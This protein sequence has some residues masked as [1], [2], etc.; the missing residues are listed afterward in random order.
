[1]LEQML[2]SV[3]MN[4]GPQP[5]EVGYVSTLPSY[6][7]IGDYG[8]AATLLVDDLGEN[9]YVLG[10]YNSAGGLSKDFTVYNFFLKKWIA[11]PKIDLAETRHLSMGYVQDKIYVIN[12]KYIR[13]FD[14]AT[15]TWSSK[16]GVSSS[17]WGYFEQ[18]QACVVGTKIYFMGHSTDYAKGTGIVSYDTVTNTFALVNR[19]GTALKSYVSVKHI[20]GKLYCS[21]V[22]INSIDVYDITANTWTVY[23]ISEN[24]G[25]ANSLAY[26][27]DMYYFGTSTP[28]A[29]PNK[30]V[31]KFDTIT[32]T[33]TYLP[34][35]PR[36]FTQPFITANAGNTAFIQGLVSD[37]PRTFGITTYVMAE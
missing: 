30:N 18:S 2:T 9:L 22:T 10:G 36:A 25:A 33:L 17:Q 13:I 35:L 11:L 23:P 24:I 5:G 19:W 27:T 8:A 1:M 3:N 21:P 34:V 12:R 26:G 4:T 14:I 29:T 7:G 16:T 32:H 37:N 6:A 20:N 15:G 28:A 31:L